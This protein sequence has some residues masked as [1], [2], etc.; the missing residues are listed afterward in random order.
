M[1]EKILS[2]LKGVKKAGSGFIALCPAHDDQHHSLSISQG[3]DGRVLLHCHTG[4]TTENIVSALGLSLR[5]LFPDGNRTHS[6]RRDEITYDYRNA[7]GELVYQ[8]VRFEPKD[9]RQRRPDG[10]GGWIW[11]MRGV[12]P[13][14]YRLPQL[15]RVL[16]AGELVFIVEGE[17]DADKLAAL[18]LTATTN[19]GGAG[20]WRETHSKHFPVGTQVMILP[21]NDEPGR[22]HA[23]EVARQ[24]AGCGCQVKVV[25]LPGLP[26][27][28]DVS[29]WLNAGRS[30]QELL[31]LVDQAGYW[32]APGTGTSK[33]GKSINIASILRA[34]DLS[35]KIEIPWAIP[36][37]LP[38]G[39]VS[40]LVG[41]PK[42]GKTWLTLRLACE[43][44]RGGSILAGL[45]DVEPVRVLYLMGDT[46]EGLVNYR[47]HRTG[48]QF[49]PD[50]IRLV[51]SEDVR[52]Q[53]VDLDFSSQEGWHVLRTLIAA[54]QPE[55]VFVDTLTSF[56]CADE[57]DNSEIRPII[58]GL[59]DIA[60]E[61]NVAMVVLHH[62]R[63]RKTRDVAMPISQ[64]D[65]V[66]AGVLARLCGN[67]IG[68]E[69]KTGDDGKT[70]HLVRSLA[71]WF[72]EF[73]PFSFTLVDVEKDGRE[74]VEMAV[75]LTPE[76]A[77]D[78]R[79]TIERHIL[80]HYSTGVEFTRQ[81]VSRHTGISQRHVG[82]VLTDLLKEGMLTAKGNSRN[83]VFTYCSTNT[84]LENDSGQDEE[85]FPKGGDHH[86]LNNPQSLKAVSE[87]FRTSFR[88]HV[89]NMSRIENE[90]NNLGHIQDKNINPCPELNPANTGLR[91]NSG[92]D[93]PPTRQ[94]TIEL[95][96]KRAVNQNT[97]GNCGINWNENKG[98][99]LDEIPF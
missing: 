67:I 84:S 95:C 96:K 86:V 66:G 54:W 88:T 82:R 14:P 70:F 11:N 74:M 98:D 6:D 3:Q 7:A 78:A 26:E 38:K 99:D 25:E 89:P 24:L 97:N 42:T 83:R 52:R 49:R 23:Q 58:A 60:S 92:H 19:H 10:A 85:I 73:E 46:G 43:L 30:K 18:D 48:W 13:V 77:G 20:K 32:R 61:Y 55:V 69:R 75:D 36:D 65:T 80:F 63:K 1:F 51:Y 47:L 8:V 4:C 62:A 29:D 15:V 39:Y 40:L 59:R 90:E 5:D 41:D 68:L 9:F 91:G 87:I 31:Q 28:G 2:G 35:R 37:M 76:V 17:K 71:S 56:H 64:H 81:D 16:E 44:S 53:G 22:K 33:E 45:A 21:D 57:S 79:G 94:Q 27:K 12:D 93:V 34:P 50:N 72:K